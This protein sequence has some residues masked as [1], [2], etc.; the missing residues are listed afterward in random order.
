MTTDAN[1]L[2][3]VLNVVKER[4]IE[5][6]ENLRVRYCR[7]LM[8]HSVSLTLLRFLPSYLKWADVVHLTAVYSF[9]TIPTL[10]AC[11]IL[12]KP[13]VWTPRGAFRRWQGSTKVQV[14]AVW[15]CICRSVAPGRLVLHVTSEEEAKESLEKFPKLKT[16]IIPN[17]VTIPDQVTHHISNR[18]LRLLYLGRLHPIKG[19]ENLL[20]ACNILS[21]TSDNKWLLTIAGPGDQSYIRTLRALIEELELSQQVKMLGEV[22]GEVKKRV[23]ENADI[24]ILPSYTENF[25][26]VV[27]EALVYGVPVIASKGTPWRRVEEKKCGLWVSNDAESLARAIKQMSQMPL[28]EMGLRGREWMQREFSWNTKAEEMVNLYKTLSNGP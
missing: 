16:F 28:G 4:E 12:D 10:L 9:P 18:S 21:G 22:S 15:E 25:G 27:A 19:I 1:G 7:R 14:K 3:A 23:F 11:K 26:M 20:H 17:G 24:V 8:R 13:V 5:I 2:S 6:A